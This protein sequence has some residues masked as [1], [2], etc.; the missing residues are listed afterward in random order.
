MQFGLSEEQILLL[1]N[2]NRFL[3]D[4]SPLDRVRLY[5]DGGDD[6]DI[7]AGL[8]ELGIPAPPPPIIIAE[9]DSESGEPSSRELSDWLTDGQADENRNEHIHTTKKG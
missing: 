2:V 7:W 5:A 9:H 8:A 1:D 3:D 4:N 6:A